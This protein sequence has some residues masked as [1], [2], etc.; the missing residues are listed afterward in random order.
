[1]S[2]N[3][4]KPKFVYVSYIATTPEELWQALEQEVEKEEVEAVH[5]AHVHHLVPPEELPD[6][7]NL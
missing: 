4:G 5:R 7:S 3:G 6:I 1:M 2:D